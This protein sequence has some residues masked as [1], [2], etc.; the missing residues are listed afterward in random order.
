[1]HCSSFIYLVESIAGVN[2]QDSVCT[3]IIKNLG[4]RMY[5][6]LSTMTYAEL[7]GAD[8]PFDLLLQKRGNG[9]ANYSSQYLPDTYWSHSWV[10]IQRDEPAGS[11][12]FQQRRMVT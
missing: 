7:Q 5:G 6:G 11:V 1:M 4:H 12:A 10:L 2:Q 3:I 8:C 9:L